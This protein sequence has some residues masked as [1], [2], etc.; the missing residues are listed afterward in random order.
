MFTGCAGSPRC[1]KYPW[2]V[3]QYSH[4]LKRGMTTV[5]MASFVPVLIFCKSLLVPVLASFALFA[6]NTVAI[7]SFGFEHG[8]RTQTG[9]A[10]KLT[11]CNHC[12][13]HLV[14]LTFR[15]TFRWVGT[16]ELAPFWRCTR[17]PGRL[18]FSLRGWRSWR[19]HVILD[20]IT[21]RKQEKK[22]A[23]FFVL[24]RYISS[25]RMEYAVDIAKWMMLGRV[26]SR[27]PVRSVVF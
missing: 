10:A 21:S 16:H 11:H 1:W 13:R 4:L 22:E 8:T 25:A 5:R 26:S 12:Q 18:V 6:L 2:T 15:L 23:I 19:W 27:S 17:T 3:V 7:I 14:G 9:A 24:V 20:A